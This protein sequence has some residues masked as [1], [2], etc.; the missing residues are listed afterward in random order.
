MSLDRILATI[1]D[2][3]TGFIAAS[4][5]ASLVLVA[6]LVL[7]LRHRRKILDFLRTPAPL[8]SDAFPASYLLRKSGLIERIAKKHGSSVIADLGLGPLWIERLLRRKRYADFRR[9]LTFNISEGLFACFVAS[10]GNKRRM[11]T[12]EQAIGD[13]PDAENLELIAA[14]SDGRRL[15]VAPADRLVDIWRDHLLTLTG[16]QE[17]QIRNF[18][19]QLLSREDTP[20]IRRAKAV[21]LSDSRPENRVLA[22][23]LVAADDSETSGTLVALVLD[24]PVA[25]VRSAAAA[26]LRGLSLW[27]SLVKLEDLNVTQRSHVA[28]LLNPTSDYETSVAIDWLEKGDPQTQY[29]VAV[30]LDEAALLERM[31]EECD[32]GDRTGLERR[33]TILIH[34]IAVRVTGFLSVLERTNRPASLLLGAELLQQHGDPDLIRVVAERVFRMQERAVPNYLT[35]YETVCEAIGARGDDGALTLLLREVSSRKRPELIR[36]ALNAIPEGRDTLFSETLFSALSDP[37]FPERPALRRAIL[38]LDSARVL[39]ACFSILNAPDEDI[40]P[41]LRTDALSLASQLNL[42]FVLREILERT[43]ELDE[44]SVRGL[45]QVSHAMDP[46]KTE[47]TIAELIETADGPVRSALLSG[48]AELPG[49]TFLPALTAAID[50]SD[51]DVRRA[52][53]TTLDRIDELST[54]GSHPGLVRDPVPRVRTRFAI[55]LARSTNRRHISVLREAAMDDDE[56]QEIRCSIVRA[57]AANPNAHATTTLLD[58]LDATE[59]VADAATEALARVPTI[60]SVRLLAQRFGDASAEARRRIDVSTR[61]IAQTNES[62]LLESAVDAEESM[63]WALTQLFEAT[64]YMTELLHRLKHREPLRRIQAAETMGRLRGVHAAAGVVLA[65]WDSNSQVQAAVAPA[66]ERLKKELSSDLRSEL[67]SHPLRRVRKY[68]ARTFG[69]VS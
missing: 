2:G 46:E 16:H 28:P 23:E 37:S 9:V 19:L 66:L 33:R 63:A 27:S 52:A 25:A 54:L 49:Q 56:L 20:Q 7:R 44:D 6:L 13:D 45:L 5:L 50:D 65:S 68:S 60:E 29:P 11:L 34:A 55:A 51:P 62:L 58:L 69:P 40:A 36:A 53:I 67:D 8:R 12:F 17:W 31:L 43:G 24:D 41:I 1:F 30:L 61:A 18:A 22:V 32:F 42:D 26:R 39:S 4:S 35:I 59:S 14:A 47:H 3:T 21:A 48:I 38:R 57:L 15:D 64:G 10:L